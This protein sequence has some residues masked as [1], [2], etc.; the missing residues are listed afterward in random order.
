LSHLARAFVERTRGETT[1]IDALRGAIDD[2][3]S[4]ATLHVKRRLDVEQR[5]P[6]W[7]LRMRSGAPDPSR[8]RLWPFDAETTSMHLGA[9]RL[10]LREWLDE[11]AGEADARWL[12]ENGLLVERVRD[13]RESGPLALFAAR[14]AKT[15]AQAR[16]VHRAAC[17]PGAEWQDAARWMG[18]ALGYPRC[19]VE[20]F[21]RARMRDDVAMFA[22]L[23]PPTDD[24]PSSPRAGWLV[25]ATTPISHA[26][27]SSSCAPTLALASSTLAAIDR[28]YPGF[29]RLWEQIARRVHAIDGRGRCFALEVSGALDG[30]ARVAHAIELV[31]P[32]DDDRAMERVVVE[33][34]TLRA[35]AVSIDDHRLVARVEGEERL[36]A[37]LFCDQRG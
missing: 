29:L 35:S 7:P 1:A 34:A 3:L 8:G 20:S 9:R 17:T 2:A 32:S 21:V 24:P 16:E 26:P 5:V 10:V 37:G 15:I 31:P 14:D 6:R 28:R 27:C 13:R 36:C 23:L 19:C 4:G 25:G 33:D 30:R 18:D 11:A 12:E 22:D